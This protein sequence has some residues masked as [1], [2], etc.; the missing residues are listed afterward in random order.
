MTLDCVKPVHPEPSRPSLEHTC[1]LLV[2]LVM[3]V[4]CQE[5]L[6]PLVFQDFTR[7]PI[8]EIA[9]NVP[10][11]L[12]LTLLAPLSVKSAAVVLK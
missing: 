9:F 6:V 8:W 10:L 7:I 4:I 2:V 11:E 12:M 3:K 1:A 5:L